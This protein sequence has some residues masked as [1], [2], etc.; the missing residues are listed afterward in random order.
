MGSNTADTVTVLKLPE[1]AERVTLQVYGVLL[2]AS[3]PVNPLKTEPYG[4]KKPGV[5]SG[6]A[7]SV[8][9]LGRVGYVAPHCGG[10][11]MRWSFD[12]TTPLP[13]PN[14]LTRRTPVTGCVGVNVAV[15][16]IL[17]LRT[18]DVVVPD[19]LQPVCHPA[20]ANPFWAVAVRMT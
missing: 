20:K 19:P 11:L 1:A 16:V 4:L 9:V 7:V 8:I 10:Q 12:V 3:H 18:R 5:R 13:S 17:L 15:H 6:A 2:E 14:T